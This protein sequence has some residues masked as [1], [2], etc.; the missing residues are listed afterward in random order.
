M[1]RISLE[2]DPNASPE[3]KAKYEKA[4]GGNGSSTFDVCT[5]CNMDLDE[6][7]EV[8][9][10]DKDKL[11]PY[12]GEPEGMRYVV[13]KDVSHPPYEGDDYVCALCDCE[14]TEEDD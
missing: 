14:L 4:M 6:N 1:P 7:E 11:S 8:Y 9:N 5:N 3:D 2:L 13:N 12:N 10:C